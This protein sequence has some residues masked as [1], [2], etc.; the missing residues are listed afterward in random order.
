MNTKQNDT[1]KKTYSTPQA[2][3]VSLRPDASLCVFS[4]GGDGN[5]PTITIGTD[6]EDGGD[7]N[8]TRESG[9]IWDNEW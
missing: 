8:L 7:G 6:E 1:M 3:I 2:L 4:P 9:S 5:D